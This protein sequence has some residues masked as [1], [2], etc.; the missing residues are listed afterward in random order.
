[1]KLSIPK[2]KIFFNEIDHQYFLDEDE[3]KPLIGVSALMKYFGYVPDYDRFPAAKR[4][5][6]Y[7]TAV[8]LTVKL[9]DEGTLESYD[10]Q[11]EPE[12]KAWRELCAKNKMK[13]ISIEQPLVSTVW[14]FAGIPDRITEAGDLIDIKTGLPQPYHAIQTALYKILAEENFDIK[15][16]TRLVVELRKGHK[17]HI[18]KD[19]S[20]ES[21]AK[22][23]LTLY[24]DKLRKGL[25]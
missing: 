23:M 2:N 14:N 5:A 24:R 9:N 12:V 13:F 7:G 19:R 8:H 17:I 21:V 16:R 18:H 25:V 3:T 20:D 4:A 10:P 15:I 11:I 6:D 22:S 1:M